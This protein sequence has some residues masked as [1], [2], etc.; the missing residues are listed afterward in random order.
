MLP[1]FPLFELPPELQLQILCKCDLK[2]VRR[3]LRL[4]SKL[5][6][7]FLLYPESS[8]RNIL[9]QLPCSVANLLL[10]SWELHNCESVDFDPHKATLLFEYANI[11]ET[12]ANTYPE[13]LYGDNNPIKVL[14]G[15][16]DLHEEVSTISEIY[17]QSANAV[18]EAFASPHVEAKPITLSTTEYTRLACSFL[19]L[20][21]FY[22]LHTKY[23][24]HNQVNAFISAFMRH[25]YPW[26]IEQIMSVEAFLNRLDD[27]L[28][29]GL[30]SLVN[31]KHAAKEVIEK[32]S[33]YVR[34]YLEEAGNAS[35]FH[36]FPYN[37]RPI[38]FNAAKNTLLL[39]VHQ[40]RNPLSPNLFL[41]TPKLSD[42]STQLRN[43]G[44]IY[45]EAANKA[46]SITYQQYRDMFLQLG[47]FFWDQG[48]L[49]KWDLADPTGFPNAMK[50]LKERMDQAYEKRVHM[51]EYTYCAMGCCVDKQSRSKATRIYQW[52]RCP[53]QCSFEEWE[54]QE[55][56][57]LRYRSEMRYKKWNDDREARA[58]E[59]A[60]SLPT[61]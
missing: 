36:G 46:S 50:M 27:C 44:W 13:I 22:Q 26:Q 24:H 38:T 33:L 8:L 12:W 15:L 31:E 14:E 28:Y 3:L 43:H 57:L 45:F 49:A 55:S 34:N 54:H 59:A 52:T 48:R 18:M 37:T 41:D 30:Y 32:K 51:V 5:R 10:A 25:L 23:T 2:S 39:G 4:S 21:I 20:K 61:V 19:M 35:D 29:P 1:S 56:E 40:R 9:E 16:E 60:A 42:D 17:A 11:T 53:I 6:D 58:A 47:V 7:L